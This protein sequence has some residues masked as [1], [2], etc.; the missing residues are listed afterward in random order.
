MIQLDEINALTRKRIL[1]GIVDNYFKQGPIMQYLR[2]NRLKDYIGGPQIQENY[3]YKP[4]KGGAYKKGQSFDVT[5]H[6][7]KTG[8]LFEPRFYE[9]NVTEFLEDIEVIVTGPEAVM[10]MVDADLS[11]A[12]LTLS[13][14]LEIAILHHGQNLQGDDRSSEINGL[15]EA[16]GSAAVASWAGN[17]FPNY[18]GQ[19][20]A[21]VAPALNSPGSVNGTSLVNA[22]VG[23]P[24]DIRVLEHSYQSCKIGQE[25][26]KLGVT[27][28]RCTG[29][30]GENFWGQV[31][32]QDTKDPVIGWT[33]L[34]FKEA[35]IVDSNY[36]PGG[37]GENDPLLGNYLT[38]D[39]YETFL[40]LNPGGEGDKSYMSLHVST[41]PRYR[42]GFTG[43]KVAQDNLQIAGQLLFGGNFSIRAPRLMRWLRG[44]RG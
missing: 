41:S 17:F 33:G 15:E 7:T 23:G 40:W 37:E 5:K 3:L 22:D 10:S 6:Q 34:K 30:I 13:A 11:N 18:G 44:I 9:V 14:I 21:S 36:F 20:R 39:G 32:L 26:P 29:F 1:R 25:V 24:I 43:F 16:L 19:D 27:T 8:L 28:P 38:P 35:T 4:M 12:A 42:F 2:A 31:R